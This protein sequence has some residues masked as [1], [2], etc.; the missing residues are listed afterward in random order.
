VQCFKDKALQQEL[1]KVT[2]KCRNEGCPW[3]GLLENYKVQVS[4][5]LQLYHRI[6]GIQCY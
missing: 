2:L 4:D 6:L 5:L 1:A 3:E